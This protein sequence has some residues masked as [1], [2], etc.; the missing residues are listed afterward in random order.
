METTICPIRL[1]DPD[2]E[3]MVA[4]FFRAVRWDSFSGTPAGIREWPRPGGL[5]DQ[6][7]RLVAAVDLLLAE[8]QY[9]PKARAPKERKEPGA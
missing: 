7:A 3:A 9:L 1:V 2:S 4:W 8:V 5:M 6:D